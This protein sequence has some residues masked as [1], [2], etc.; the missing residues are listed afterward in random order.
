MKYI[1][2][3]VL[4]LLTT[5]MLISNSYADISIKN[6]WFK[7]APPVAPIR[8]AYMTIVNLSDTET[9]IT[10]LTSPQFKKVEIHQ[11]S[12][13]DG[14]YSMSQLDNVRIE[15]KANISLKPRGTH[16]MLMQP[17]QSLFG[18]NEIQISVYSDNNSV[19]TLTIP[20]KD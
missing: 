13:N 11:T 12:L 2:K 5:V 18:L 19:V 14:V 17:T 3:F 4:T 7:K 15:A 6:A 1:K 16:L 8:A 9:K 20:A 10:K